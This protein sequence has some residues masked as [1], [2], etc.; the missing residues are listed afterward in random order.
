[1][2]FHCLF[3]LA[4]CLSFATSVLAAGSMGSGGG[5]VVRCQI[6]I[7][8]AANFE[9]LDVYEARQ[10]N[11]APDLGSPDLGFDQKL[12]IALA[13]LRA[14]DP[15][16]AREYRERVSFFLNN[17]AFLENIALE[18]VP[19]SDPVILQVGCSI[20]QAVV[21]RP[22]LHPSDRLFIVDN[23]IWN[24]LDVDNK[25]ALAL[26]E[27]IYEEAVTQF[28]H[29]NSA[30]SRYLNSLVLAGQFQYANTQAYIEFLRTIGFNSYEQRGA[31]FLIDSPPYIWESANGQSTTY[32]TSPTFYPNGELKQVYAIG[33]A[34]DFPFV[35]RLHIPE[36]NWGRINFFPSGNICII[37][38]ADMINGSFTEGENQIVLR[39]HRSDTPDFERIAF[40]ENG[41]LHAFF[42]HGSDRRIRQRDGGFYEL[43]ANQELLMVE[44]DADGYFARTTISGH[45]P[46]DNDLCG[47]AL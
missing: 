39:A 46:Y 38:Y 15:G 23:R 44:I 2:R 32:D 33:S 43:R 11:L 37:N 8:G 30:R 16:R 35:F 13:R 5:G 36:Q 9:T 24:S 41:H 34:P 10:R 45:F 4:S 47:G 3:K 42:S 31:K 20:L 25:V 28:G 27:V 17:A 19:D 1:M 22:V 26:H 21:R 40:Y 14:R 29:S 6:D 12:E 18:R 7:N